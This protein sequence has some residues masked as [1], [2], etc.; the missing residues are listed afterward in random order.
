MQDPSDGESAE[1]GDHQC[2][3]LVL[4]E[5]GVGRSSKPRS[6]AGADH[7]EEESDGIGARLSDVVLRLC[8]Y[9]RATSFG[10]EDDHDET[11]SRLRQMR[12]PYQ[13]DKNLFFFK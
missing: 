8:R 11:C 6:E 9:L 7:G 3:G 4:G 10:C 5:E 2:E 1:R 12:Q 13:H